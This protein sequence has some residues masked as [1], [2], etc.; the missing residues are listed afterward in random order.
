MLYSKAQ[1]ESA[2][3]DSTIQ[4][5]QPN[6]GA[7]SVEE[8]STPAIRVGSRPVVD[9]RWRID[10]HG[11]VA[12]VIAIDRPL[13]DFAAIGAVVAEIERLV[14]GLKTGDNGA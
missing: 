12:L 2:L 13:T 9:Q 7:A 1:A 10:H 6:V 4:S 5:G 11:E 8:R 3:S 14:A